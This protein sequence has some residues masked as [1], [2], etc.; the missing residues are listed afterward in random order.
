MCE[1][2]GERERREKEEG[3]KSRGIPGRTQSGYLS[4]NSGGT[5]LRTQGLI[6]NCYEIIKN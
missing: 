1:R 2:E 4:I 6:L 3:R 5:E